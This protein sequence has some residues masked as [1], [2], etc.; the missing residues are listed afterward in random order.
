MTLKAKY[1]LSAKVFMLN[2]DKST[3]LVSGKMT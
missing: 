1:H 2:L 3:F